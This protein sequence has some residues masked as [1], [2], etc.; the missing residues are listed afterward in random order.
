[1]IEDYDALARAVADAGFFTNGVEDHG[2][3]HRTCVCSKRR[4]DGRLNGNSFWV[5]RRPGGWYLGTWGPCLYR[6][7]D[8]SRL[9]ELCIRWLSH[10]PD[11]VRYDFDD[12]LKSEFGLV[13]VSDKEFE[14]EKGS[15]EI[16]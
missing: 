9:A 2:A 5:S 11:S 13:P 8:E 12:W 4:P 3:W 16:A 10:A 1:M 14:G 7:A 6:L 15:S